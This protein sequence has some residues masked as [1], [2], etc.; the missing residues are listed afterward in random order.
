MSRIQ[1]ANLNKNKK[2]EGKK[3]RR[4]GQDQ[5]GCFLHINVY[6]SSWSYGDKEQN[7][8]IIDEQET[9]EYMFALS[10]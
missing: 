2:V 1:E 6:D 10:I 9:V 4:Y 3:W 5:R 7:L 8:G